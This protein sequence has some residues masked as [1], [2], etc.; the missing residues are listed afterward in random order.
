MLFGAGLVLGGAAALAGTPKFLEAVVQGIAAES[1]APDGL[2]HGVARFAVPQGFSESHYTPQVL[3]PVTPSTMPEWLPRAILDMQRGPPPALS[4]ARPVIA[5]CIDDLGE[6]LAGTDRAMALPEAVAL[7]FLPFAEATPF[8]ADAA[9]RKGHLVLAHVPMQALGLEDPGPMTLTTGMAP[10]EIASRMS[11]NLTRVPGLVGINNHE[12]SRFTADAVGLAP[13]MATLRA[14]HL[15]FFDSRTGPDSAVPAAARAAGVMTAGRDVFLDDDQ[16][17]AAVSAQ[18]E[19]LAREAKR[20]GV[21]IAIG[22]PHDA[23]LRLLKDWLAHDHGVTLV[24]LDE[25]MRRK[26]ARDIAIVGR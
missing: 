20:R 6:D 16:R 24:P 26:V 8:L 11:W 2:A 10:N 21:A 22:H 9:A 4:G 5:I 12:G 14:R 19:I 3:Y 17:E 13:V 18:L 1:A 23:T 15:F 25:A 7:S